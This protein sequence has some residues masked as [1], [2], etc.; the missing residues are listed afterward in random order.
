MNR[1][2][3][4]CRIFRNLRLEPFCR[5]T[6]EQIIEAH[7]F[8]HDRFL[9]QQKV[10]RGRV[11]ALLYALIFL[12]HRKSI[13]YNNLFQSASCYLNNKAFLSRQLSGLITYYLWTWI[14]SV[15]TTIWYTPVHSNTE[16]PL[17][18]PS[19][20]QKS[21]DR[22]PIKRVCANCKST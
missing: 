15:K 9:N 11:G 12:V 21:F 5:K 14:P 8:S 10:H 1:G 4:L 18:K 2:S 22:L 16:T 3:F 13:I 7:Q 17:C 6:Y 20:Q 19:H